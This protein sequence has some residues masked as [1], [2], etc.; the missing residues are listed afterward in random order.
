LLRCCRRPWRLLRV[1]AHAGPRDVDQKVLSELFYSTSTWR[2]IS[3]ASS[4]PGARPN[5]AGVFVHETE[6]PAGEDLHVLDHE[7]ASEVVR[8][9]SH[10]GWPCYCRHRWST[11]AAPATR[12][13]TSAVVQQHGRLADPARHH[14]AGG[15]RRGPGIAGGGAGALLV[16]FGENVARA[17]TSSAMLRL[18][19]RGHDR[20][21]PVRLPPAVHPANY[22]RR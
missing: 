14:P 2:R 15:R 12:R 3:S 13:R 7:R 20:R 22:C 18:L 11:W 1:L 16:Q 4:S 17:S 10:I 8:T 9:A 21:P 6:L 19:L 5:W